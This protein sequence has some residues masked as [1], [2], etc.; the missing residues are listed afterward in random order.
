M[1]ESPLTTQQR[2]RV[3]PLKNWLTKRVEGRE[4]VLDILAG[5]LA[6]RGPET[7]SGDQGA[8]KHIAAVA[9]FRASWR[10]AA[11]DRLV[12]TLAKNRDTTDLS[13][14]L[15]RYLEVSREH[16]AHAAQNPTPETLNRLRGWTA[17]RLPELE[18]KRSDSVY[19]TL[20]ITYE[21]L[22]GLFASARAELA[23]SGI[24]GSPALWRPIVR[25][26]WVTE[27]PGA[28]LSDAQAD[29]IAITPSGRVRAA[30]AM[31]MEMLAHLT[32]RDAADLKKELSRVRLGPPAL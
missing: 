18:R 29:A 22:A 16:E 31:A 1:T 28:R 20:K 8:L 15:R 27:R 7:A 21:Y 24:K 5:I 19:R 9:V 13:R 2:L 14:R 26:A 3:R 32:G 6:A 25:D 30:Q 10:D 11:L 17:E 23:A 12:I 4:Q